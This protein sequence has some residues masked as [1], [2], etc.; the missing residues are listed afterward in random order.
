MIKYDP[1]KITYRKL[2][3]VFF[4]IHD[5]TTPNQQGN[6]KGSQYRSAIFYL[7]DI[8]KYAALDIINLANESNVFNHQV[9]TEISLFKQFYIAEKY[10]QKYLQKHPDGYTCHFIRNNWMF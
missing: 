6:D 5:P 7:N 1:K 10:H 4:T 2:L 3:K 8:Q 9:I